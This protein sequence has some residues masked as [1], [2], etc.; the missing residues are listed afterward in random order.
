MVGQS[1]YELLG[2]KQQA[3][4]FELLVPCESTKFDE[5]NYSKAPLLELFLTLVC[6]KNC[7]FPNLSENLVTGLQ[8]ISRP[9]I[10]LVE[11]MD[12]Y[13]EMFLAS[14]TLP[15]SPEQIK[16]CK[17]LGIKKLD[18]NDELM[19]T[20]NLKDL[21]KR[22]KFNKKQLHDLGISFKNNSHITF[23]EQN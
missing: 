15:L 18:T 19:L 6:A 17:K 22:C 4:L 21:A 11:L 14:E 2:K 20:K 16:L 9:Y 3:K 1:A 12:R 5:L 7:L 23:E 8:E 10:Q 13:K